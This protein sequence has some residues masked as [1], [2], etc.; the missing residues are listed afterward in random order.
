M[1]AAKAALAA[2]RQGAYVAF[3]KQLMRSRFVPD[4][5]FL[6]EIAI[7]IGIDGTQMLADME[8]PEVAERLERSDAVAGVLAFPGTPAVVVGRTVILGAVDD[9]T[10]RAVIAAEWSA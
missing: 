8:G 10:L 9:A 1:A 2:D 3:H 7:S 6:R 4:D 5:V